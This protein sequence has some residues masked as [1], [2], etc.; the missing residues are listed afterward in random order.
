LAFALPAANLSG[1]SA[2][3]SERPAWNAEV[4]DRI[5]APHRVWARRLIDDLHLGGDEAVLDAGCGAGSVTLQLLDSLPRGKVYA[6]D[7]S[8]DMIEKITR[9][10]DERDLTSVIPIHADLTD[11]TLPEPVDCV[12]SNAVFHWIFDDDALFSCLFRA[13]R[14]G[15]LLRA[16]C[17]GG[18]NI[19]RHTAVAREV[20][21]REPFAEYL[22]D[23][24]S[25]TNFR[26]TTA[27]ED[28]M[29]RAGWTDARASLFESP[30]SFDDRDD[31]ITYVRTI[32]L[33]GHV[34][35][36]P[37]ALRD[38]FLNAVY[39]EQLRRH[40]APFTMD[41]VR[42]DLWATRPAAGQTP[43]RRP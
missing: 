19:A 26:S 30:V 11:F 27:T 18:H 12:F 24:P 8:L 9:T 7:S 29:R 3:N 36:L 21:G 35:A 37:D 23:H 1:M 20:R 17:G 15:G 5:N 42:L 10:V 31:A 22:A 28:A 2:T 33:R 14:P 25:S 32:T 43:G 6:V 34:A 40:G 39:E 38:P 41:Y 4:Y 13:T 16:Q